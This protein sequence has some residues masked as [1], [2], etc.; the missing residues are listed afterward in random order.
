MKNI[1]E[2]FVTLIEICL[3]SSKIKLLLYESSRDLKIIKIFNKY[4]LNQIY[5]NNLSN[6][7]NKDQFSSPTDHILVIELNSYLLELKLEMIDEN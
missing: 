4:I 6:Y 1:F 2:L 5:K 7:G 3:D